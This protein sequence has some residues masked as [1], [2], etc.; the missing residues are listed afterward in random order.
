[1]RSRV[2]HPDEPTELLRWRCVTNASV[3][4]D[5]GLCGVRCRVRARCETANDRWVTQK[6]AVVKSTFDVVVNLLEGSN[7]LIDQLD[8]GAISNENGLRR[9]L[10]KQAL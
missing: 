10:R 6:H 2:V 5:D 4:G 3:D 9:F 1:M 8:L 7:S